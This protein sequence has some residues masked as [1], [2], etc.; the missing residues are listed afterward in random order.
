MA[1]MKTNLPTIE[2]VPVE[3]DGAFI[4]T[5]LRYTLWAILILSSVQTALFVYHSLTSPLRDV[6]GPFLARFGRFY[7]LLKVAQGRW[8]H[9]DIRLHRQHGPVVR[10]ASDMYSIDSP[11]VVRKV[12]AINSKFPKADWYD[13]WKHPSPDRW[14]LFP[15]RD[16]KRHAETRKRFQAMYSMSSLVNY[17]GY[18]DECAEVFGRR[19]TEFASK[20]QVIDMGRWFQLY[21]FGE[22]VVLSAGARGEL[23][24]G[25]Q[26]SRPASADLSYRRHWG[27]HVFSE[28]RVLG[29]RRRYRWVARSL[30]WCSQVWDFG[31]HLRQVASFSFWYLGQAR[32][33]WCSRQE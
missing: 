10:V 20:G 27:Y 28:I 24:S 12:Y 30:A 32:L 33:R 1:M 6:P 31:W 21:A 3:H 14:T 19:L 25:S 29:Q 7:Y 13:A 16:M 18:V 5:V 4:G 15:D 17:E 9:D 26:M 8:E 22:F 11:D 2:V 23:R